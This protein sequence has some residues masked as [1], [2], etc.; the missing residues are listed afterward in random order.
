M[1]FIQMSNKPAQKGGKHLRSVLSTAAATLL[2]AGWSSSAR[3][4]VVLGGGGFIPSS[5]FT[6]PP[7]ATVFGDF[8]T[9]TI[10]KSSFNERD[11]L[12][13]YSFNAMQGQTISLDIDNAANGGST[14]SLNG[15]YNDL[16]LALFSGNGALLAYNDNSPLDPGSVLTFDGL[17]NNTISRDPFIGDYNLTYPNSNVRG[18]PVNS[19]LDP[20]RN[21]YYIAVFEGGRFAPTPTGLNNSGATTSPLTRLDGLSGGTAYNYS[22]LGYD[23]DLNFNGLPSFTQGT[24]T[25]GLSPYTLQVSLSAAPATAPVPEP[26]T[27][28]LMGLGLAGLA[29]SRRRKKNKAEAAAIVA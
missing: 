1:Q 9:A 15:G 2:L 8:P 14:S 5:A 17:N 13:I 25:F 4:D 21:T 20:N 19:S 22:Q 16:R 26:G 28:A 3:A 27:M 29:A 23:T 12:D 24:R 10:E 6:T 11:S 18:T 7:P